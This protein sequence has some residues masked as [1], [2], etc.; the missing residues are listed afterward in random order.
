[1]EKVKDLLGFLHEGRPY[2]FI[3]PFIIVFLCAAWC[4]TRSDH[5]MKTLEKVLWFL[6]GGGAIGSG[7]HMKKK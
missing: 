3:V 7:F 2:G 1:M 4:A 6:L 5:I